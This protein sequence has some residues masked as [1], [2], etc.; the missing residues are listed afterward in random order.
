MSSKLLLTKK[1]RRGTAKLS[2]QSQ[3]KNV[4]LTKSNERWRFSE[5]DRGL[6][7]SQIPLCVPRTSSGSSQEGS[8]PGGSKKAD[9][10]REQSTFRGKCRPPS[11]I[12]VG[13]V[14]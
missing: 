12:A 4:P 9:M 3:G 1:L 13:R 11:G 8:N 7:K 14:V 5:L 2:S 6:K 10:Y